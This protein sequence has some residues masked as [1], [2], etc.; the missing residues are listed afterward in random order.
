MSECEFLTRKATIV[1]MELFLKYS[2]R[3]ENGDWNWLCVCDFIKNKISRY[4]WQECTA[5]LFEYG[6]VE[7]RRN[8][9][10]TVAYRLNRP[11]QFYTD[12]IL[13]SQDRI[14]EQEKLKEQKKRS[15]FS[16]FKEKFEDEL[17]AYAGRRYE[18]CQIAVK[19]DRYGEKPHRQFN[20]SHTGYSGENY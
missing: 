6:L 15:N 16:D 4:L 9:D 17:R 5:F 18:D 2:V 14:A 1:Y 3:D 10:N 8:S 11:K 20:R 19:A 12:L 7:R 13:K